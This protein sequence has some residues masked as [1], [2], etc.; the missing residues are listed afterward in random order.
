MNEQ[1]DSIGL[2]LLAVLAGHQGMISNLAWEPH[3]HVLATT[4]FDKTL[5][6]WEAQQ[7]KNLKTIKKHTRNITTLAWAPEGQALATAG[8]DRMIVLWSY[9]SVQAAGVL[10]DFDKGINALAWSPNGKMLVSA[11]NS[12]ELAV[13]DPK[14]R[15]LQKR[16]A[17]HET[18]PRHLS[19]SRKGEWIASTSDSGRIRVWKSGGFGLHKLLEGHEGTVNMT[20]WLP[21]DRLVSCSDDGSIRIWDTGKNRCLHT[22]EV[23]LGPVKSV[24]VSADGRL[25]ASKS[26]DQTLRIWRCDTWQAVRVIEEEAFSSSPLLAFHPK[27]SLL[28]SVGLAG[29]VVRIWQI[30]T[31][32]LSVA[33]ADPRVFSY[34]SHELQLLRDQGADDLVSPEV[35]ANHEESTDD[36]ISC[37]HCHKR[38]PE[39]EVVRWQSHGYTS[40]KCP[41][42]GGVVPLVNDPSMLSIR[43]WVC[44]D[45]PELVILFTDIVDSTHLA[46]EL[47][48]E[49]MGVLRRAHFEK[50]RDLIGRFGGYEVKTMGDAFMIAFKDIIDAFRFALAFRVDTGHESIQIRAGFEYGEVDLEEND[51][52]GANVNKAARLQARAEA[53]E[54]WVTDAVRNRLVTEESFA[55]LPWTC[56]EDVALKGFDEKFK[57]WSV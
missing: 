29:Q 4:S 53:A 24:A 46:N 22:L 18:L 27:E 17:G 21:D 33:E 57:L 34:H 50:G 47:G 12:L 36:A 19:F 52:F 26:W 41:G 40:V 51:A 7:G 39:R 16:V 44:D 11:A 25:M 15:K 55:N 14:N 49:E 45:H 20:A 35:D 5:R 2:E 13:W 3:G 9:P 32:K 42:C 43:E 8:D 31:D 56:H 37:P 23:H 38:V 48:D 28:A 1:Q 6:I 10:D 30:E 54:I